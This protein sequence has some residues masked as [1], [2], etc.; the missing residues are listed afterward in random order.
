MMQDYIHEPGRDVPVLDKYDVVVCGGGPAGIG[1]AV[2]AARSGAR[3]LLVEATSCLGGIMGNAHV[4]CFCDSPGGPVFDELARRLLDLDAAHW[5]IKPEKFRP[6][7]RLK[8][9]PET[10][11]ALAN[12]MVQ[13]ARAALL[14]CTFASYP[15]HE[16]GRVDGVVIAT[17]SGPM[18]VPAD[19]LIDC[20]ADGDMAAGAG[21]PFL[22]GDPEDGRLQVC[23]FR[24]QGSGADQETFEQAAMSPDDLAG[25]F[26]R[27]H[28]KGAIRPPSALFAQS[29]ETFPF[30]R[31]TRKLILNNWE[32]EGIDPTDAAQVSSALAEC[33]LAALQ[34]VRFCRRHLPGYDNFRIER[35][36]VSLGT[37]ESRRI[38][39]E[40]I[41]TR[42]DVLEGRKFPDSIARAWFWLD[43]HDPPPGS[44]LPYGLEYVHANQ[45]PPDDWYEIPYRCLR[46]RG[47][48]GILVAGRCISVDRAAQSSCRIMPTCMYTGTAAGLAAA[49]AVRD[50]CD[51][52]AV[53]AAA[54]RDEMDTL[55][56]KLAARR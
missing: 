44:T 42:D 5:R 46:P 31:S 23:N 9:H 22:K 35:F 53:D 49:L 3:T 15:L 32:L 6:P 28:R 19:V 27:A 45:P 55:G 8:Y 25:L 43:F 47:L 56:K 17:K 24:W 12:E 2:S 7:G 54:I 30:D 21:A 10:T 50:R 1:A 29:R 41:L 26:E 16:D 38:V 34:I 51:P 48:E 4:G 11:R 33:Q 20:T 40:Y 13:E 14:L 18:R 39:G 52:G 36:P 37:R